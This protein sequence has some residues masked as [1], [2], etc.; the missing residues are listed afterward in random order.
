VFDEPAVLDVGRAN[1][2]RHLAFSVGETHCPGA[3]L[4]RL[5]QHI[6]LERVLDRLPDLHL[7]PGRNDFTHHPNV[8]LRAMK[9]LWVGFGQPV[10][11]IAQ[12][13][14]RRSSS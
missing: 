8:T 4:S 10:A 11:P 6:A 7:L 3:G 1:A 12:R 13:S 5:E 14:E 9:R 2:S